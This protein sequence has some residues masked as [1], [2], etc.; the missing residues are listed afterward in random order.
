MCER[1]HSD[2]LPRRAGPAYGA[3]GPPPRAESRERSSPLPRK[4][5]AALAVGI[6]VPVL[7]TYALVVYAAFLVATA[8]L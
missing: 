8:L 7:A 1:A 2:Q 4:T 3:E 5:E 6:A